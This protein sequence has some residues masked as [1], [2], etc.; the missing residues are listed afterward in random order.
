MSVDAMVSA[1]VSMK[2]ASVREQFTMG[3]TK[4]ALDRMEQ[5]GE[6]ITDMMDSGS[7]VSMDPNLGNLLDISA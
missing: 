4:M 5:T 2:A 7:A 3:V 6:A 1:A